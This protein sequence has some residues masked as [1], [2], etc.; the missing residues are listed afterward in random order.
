MKISVVT[1]VRNG[2]ATIEDA[3]LSVAAQSHADIEHIVIDGAST[4]G[5]LAVLERHR[6]KIAR[7]VSEPDRGIYD[8]M[9]KGIRLATG[10][11]IG[12]LN[13]DDVYAHTR[14][15]ER[16]AAVMAQPE[17]DACYADLVYVAR[18]DLDRVIRYWKS[19]DYRDGLCERGWLPA[20][21]TFFV[22]RRVYEKYGV[23]D[24]DYRI[25]SDFE[26]CLRLFAICKI[27]SVYVPDIWVK[28][29]LGGVT[30][31][32]ISNILK[33]NL[34]SYRACRKHGVK[35]TPFFF[36]TKIGQRIPQFFR[37]PR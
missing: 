17:V 10:D 14:V 16:V 37:R 20:H 2:V 29:R 4:D 26:L 21:P 9:N 12:M 11:V 7:L 19:R 24:L 36:I 15:L 13:A 3:I 6:D 18:D 28:M 23:F 25:Q 1:V 31:R 34:E 8:A 27:R 33:G 22:R 35:V 30:N 5:T 32:R